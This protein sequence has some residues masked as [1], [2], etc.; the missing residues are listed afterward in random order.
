MVSESSVVGVV[1]EFSPRQRAAALIL[2]LVK[3]QNK[4]PVSPA[5]QQW[6]CT[7]FADYVKSPFAQRHIELWNWIESIEPLKRPLPFVAVWPRGG[8]KSTTA[9][10]GVVRLAAKRV[11]R[12][13]WYVSS[14]QDKADQHVESIATLLESRALEHYDKLLSKRAIGK[15]G[16]SKG[17]RR[18]RLRTASG[19][20]IDALGLDTGARGAKVDQFRPDFI[21][22]DDVDEEEDSPSTTMKKIR[23]ISSTVLPAGSNDCAVLFIQ[24]L[25]HTDSIASRLIDGRA[26]FLSDRIVSGPFKAVDNAV[27]GAVD[28]KYRLTAGDPTWLGQNLEVCQAQIKTWGYTAFLREAQQEVERTGGV[29]EHIEFQHVVAGQCPVFLQTAVWVDPAVTSTDESD[30]MGISAGGVTVGGVLYGLYWWEGITTPEDALERAIWKA[31][32]VKA[33]HVGVETDQGGDT[34]QSVYA[35]ALAKVRKTLEQRWRAANPHATVEQLPDF[36]LPDF[37]SDKA[38]CGYGSKVERNTRM[39]TSYE[40]GNVVHVVGTHH[41]IERALRRFPGK[42]LDVADSWFWVWNDLVG[43]DNNMAPGVY[44]HVYA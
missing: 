28:G 39:L 43:D 19:F 9:E 40:N 42:P 23:T 37:A 3:A 25:I 20:T 33:L 8:A 32:D 26:D 31:L 22:L 5:W 2:A 30:C 24:N 27:F 18:S 17:W 36:H 10:L 11:R 41:V 1:R 6:L 16:H 38:G 13:G 29:W 12:Y 15:Y 35:I 4:R 34:W 7:L 21:V 44:S 14:T